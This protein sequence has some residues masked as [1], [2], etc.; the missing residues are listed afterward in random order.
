VRGEWKGKEGGMG[1]RRVATVRDD[2]EEGDS[3]VRHERCL[4][5]KCTAGTRWDAQRE[6]SIPTMKE[7]DA[8]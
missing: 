1:S 7:R 5:E 2:D 6:N 8:G 4:T 3:L